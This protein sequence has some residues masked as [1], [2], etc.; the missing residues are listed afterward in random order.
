VYVISPYTIDTK[1]GSPAPV[2]PIV[3]PL[4]STDDHDCRIK[5]SHRRFRKTGP[6]FSLFVV[7]CKEHN[8]GFTLYPPGYY[9]YSRH[10]LAPVSFDGSLLVEQ[11][12]NHRF[13]GTLFDAPLDAAAGNVWCQEST[14][15][16][17]MPRLTTQNRHLGR[18]ARLFGIGADGE[19]RQREEVS[20]ILM[21]PGQLLHDCSA[22]LPD[23]TALKIKGTIISRILNRIPFLTSIFERLV[24][25]GAGAGLW[26]SPLFCNPCD[27]GLHPTPFHPVRT[28]GAPDKKWG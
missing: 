27:H 17:L 6:E 24:E 1:E 8:I 18:I 13:S 19:P 2:L 22:S 7:V 14:E 20:E 4:H 15:N 9:P 16:S 3:C 25:V 26:P 10:S 23:A 12:D 11:K 21:V 5:N 28:R